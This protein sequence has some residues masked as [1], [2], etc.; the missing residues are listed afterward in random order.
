MT[1]KQTSLVMF[2]FAIMISFIFLAVL[3]RVNYDLTEAG[4]SNTYLQKQV[5]QLKSEQKDANDKI[6]G[7]NKTVSMLAHEL[8]TTQELQRKQA[9]VVGELKKGKRR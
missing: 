7:L 9:L 8:E 4:K 6:A 3:V 1:S 5:D 2:V